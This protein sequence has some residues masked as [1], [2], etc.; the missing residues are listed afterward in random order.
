[1][2]WIIAICNNQ[3]EYCS[4]QENGF[5]RRDFVQLPYYFILSIGSQGFLTLGSVSFFAFA[6][7]THDFTS[8]HINDISVILCPYAVSMSH[9]PCCNKAV[10]DS[11]ILASG[12]I[13]DRI[14]DVIPLSDVLVEP[15]AQPDLFAGCDRPTTSTCCQLLDFPLDPFRATAFVHISEGIFQ[16]PMV[17][18]HR[19]FGVAGFGD[20][21]SNIVFLVQQLMKS[22]LAIRVREVNL[23]DGIANAGDSVHH[24]FL[25]DSSSI[26]S[27]HNNYTSIQCQLVVR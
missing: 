15:L 26:G 12:M 10:V 3:F 2:Q 8:L 14:H 18:L 23:A 25:T 4:Y 24:S 6:E 13:I 19:V 11:A 21:L 1:M 5:Q 17:A 22:G 9:A 20:L 16:L 27:G 7:L